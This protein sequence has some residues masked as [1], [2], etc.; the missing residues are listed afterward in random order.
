MP[1]LIEHHCLAIRFQLGIRFEQ[2]TVKLECLDKA[3]ILAGSG[4]PIEGHDCSSQKRYSKQGNYVIRSVFQADAHAIAAPYP[5]T[6]KV[7]GRTSN[8]LG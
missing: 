6:R 8:S 5:K 4:P 1:L 3:L 7:A 2:N